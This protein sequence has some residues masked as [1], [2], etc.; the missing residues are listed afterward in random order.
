M[1]LVCARV[2]RIVPGNGPRVSLG[3]RQ[4]CCKRC[5]KSAGA[6]ALQSHRRKSSRFVSAS[7][8]TGACEPSPTPSAV[9]PLAVG[10]AGRV[11]EAL[12]QAAE[13][14]STAFKSAFNAK[15][16]D[17]E[18]VSR[19]VRATVKNM[20]IILAVA[21]FAAVSTSSSANTFL[22]ITRA[23]ASF[24]KLYLL[25]LFLRVLLS[26]FPTF[27]W[28]QQPWLALRQVTDPYLNLFRGLVPPLLGTID[29]TPLLGFF[30]LQFLAGALDLGYEEDSW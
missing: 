9:A 19:Q 2:E 1:S 4:S 20:K 5:F 7:A 15:D 21:P 17:S 22:L 26:W 11:A 24:I 16:I 12:R 30:I 10:L 23:V 18:E 28:M 14:I 8:A 13:R 27:D 25:L 6:K 29:F 3:P